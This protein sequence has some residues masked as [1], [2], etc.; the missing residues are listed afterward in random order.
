MRCGHVLLAGA[1]L[2]A[3]GDNLGESRCT[4][5]GSGPG[6]DPSGAWCER[7]SSYRLFEDLAT[8]TP[9]EGVIPYALNTPLF[10]D[11]AIKD[12]FIWVPPGEAL[13][14]SD[15]GAF[16][17][18]PGTIVI[19]TFSYLH[20]RRDL[21]QGRRTLETRLLV[22]TD[23][24]WDGAA[25]VYDEGDASDA[26]LAIAGA[27]L[28]TRWIH[29]DGNERTNAYV[30]PNKNQCKN[31]HAEHDEVIDL[32]GPKARHLNREGPPGTGI[33]DQLQ[34]LIDR[35]VLVGAPP[36]VMWPRAPAAFDPASGTLDARA[37]AWLDINCA[38]CHNS[39]G[40]ARTSGLFLDL[41]QTDP[42]V[43][44]VCKPPVA[45]GRGSGGRAFGIVPGQPDASI[46]MFRL[47]STEADIKMPE[48][49][50]NLVDEEG[51]ALIRAWIAA[52]PGSCT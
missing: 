39:R 12:R 1:L 17:A 35:G 50:R 25:Y 18:P 11:Y 36:P 24:G 29:D 23:A 20:S 38:H 41:E 8:R 22:R 31:C 52:M 7:L 37:R 14:W 43:L 5:P 15:T 13:A 34:Y 10:S 16:V 45:A 49:G 51:V 47:E 21:S 30:V 32:V 33:A 3:C 19:K 27:T 6:A 2:A 26:R 42:A 44:G 40:A 48:L 9:A 4:I 28:D 46:L